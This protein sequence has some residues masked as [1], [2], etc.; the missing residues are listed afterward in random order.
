MNHEA[1]GEVE[2]PTHGIIGKMPSITCLDWASI[3]M[4]LIYFK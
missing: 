4:C 1:D 3:E 2:G